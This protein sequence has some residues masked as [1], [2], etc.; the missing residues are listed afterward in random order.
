MRARLLSSNCFGTAFAANIFM[1]CL[2]R[3]A[4]GWSPLSN[5]GFQ[6]RRLSS[7]LKAMWNVGDVVLLRSKEKSEIVQGVVKERRGSGWYDIE[8]EQDKRKVKCRGTQLKSIAT[9]LSEELLPHVPATA[10]ASHVKPLLSS[11]DGGLAPPSPTIVDLDAAIRDASTDPVEDPSDS[12][13]LKHVRNHM[14]YDKWLVFTDLHC[15]PS[16]L[17]T[18]LQVLDHVHDL[19]RQRNAAILFL[20]DF[21]HHRGTIRVDCLNAVLGS[22]RKWDVPMVMIPGNHDQVTLGGYVHSLT[23]LQNAYR[24]DAAVPNESNRTETTIDWVLLNSTTFP[25]PLIFSH[26][27]KFLNALF[28]PHIRDNA[29]MESVLQSPQAQE[30]A[31]LFVHVDVT[32]AYMNDMIVSHGGCSP[33]MF[34]PNKP[35]YS[36]HFHRPHVVETKRKNISIEYLGSPYQV[37]LSEAQQAK[38]VAVLDSSDGWRCIERIPL[39]IGRKHFR[40]NSIDEFLRLNVSRGENTAEHESTVFVRAGDRV[41][42][43]VDN[44]HLNELRRFTPFGEDDR[45]AAHTDML[46]AADV[47]VEIRDVKEMA[48][49][50]WETDHAMEAHLWEDMSLESTWKAFL[51][52]QVRREDL[53]NATADELGRAGLN[54]I[55]D[56]GSED[57]DRYS[58]DRSSG[59]TELQLESVTVEGF[60]PFAEETTYPLLDRG[61]VLLRGSNEDGGSDRCVPLM[62]SSCFATRFPL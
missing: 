26:P 59:P 31:G 48:A 1:S 50:S 55:A 3:N 44:E 29:V 32:G 41:V 7:E 57:E 58:S 14:F 12:E 33:S 62:W 39:D 53:S 51:E 35:I 27:T 25:G 49:S 40:V 23:P 10:A 45:V 2:C 15:A 34:P 16:T 52:D 19:A 28:I 38:A 54:I 56:L 18:T 36:G 42:L 37:S 8:L 11:R 6:T 46:R 17:N 9:S 4:R 20:G 61:L 5:L 24:V 22:L 13:Y 60:G 43:T 47:T 30:A 21:W